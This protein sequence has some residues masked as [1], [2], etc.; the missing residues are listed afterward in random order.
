MYFAVIVAWVKLSTPILSKG[1]YFDYFFTLLRLLLYTAHMFR[2]LQKIIRLLIVLSTSGFTLLFLGSAWFFY[3]VHLGNPPAQTNLAFWLEH[4]WST[5]TQNNF[6]ELNERVKNLSIKDLYF[7]VGPLTETGGLAEDLDIFTP[8]LDALPSNNYAWIGQIRNKIDLEN[9]SV[10]AG[11]LESANWVL[12]RGFDGIHVDI[13]PVY[14]DDQAF[15]TL[16]E[17]LRTAYPNIKI[18]VALDHWVPGVRTRQVKA[19]APYVDQIV[20]MTYDTKFHDPALYA[21][22]VEQQTIMMSRRMPKNVELMVGIPNYETGSAIDPLA[23]NL[24]TGITGY[25]R[26]L[27]NLRSKKNRI[28][29]LAIYAYWEMD[30]SEWDLLQNL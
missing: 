10:R 30:Q 4:D 27:T 14:D 24:Q 5:G 13:E 26:A 22:W 3:G 17:E 18:S 28:G 25:Q 20:V 19:I 2:K 29:G 16:I 11:I 8:G 6:F 21:W 12:G 9:P 1:V 23:E 7:H 15:Y